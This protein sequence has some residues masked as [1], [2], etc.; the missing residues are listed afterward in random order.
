[1]SSVMSERGTEMQ[2]WM[3]SSGS[4]DTSPVNTFWTAPLVFLHL[5]VWQIPMRQP[6]AGFAPAR[7]SCSSSVPDAEPR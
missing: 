7:S 5:Q 6:E 2:S 1:M 3:S 4:L